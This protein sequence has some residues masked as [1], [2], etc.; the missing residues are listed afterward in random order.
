M[1]IRSF[2]SYAHFG[3][4]FGYPQFDMSAHGYKCQWPFGARVLMPAFGG[5]RTTLFCQ[6]AHFT[7]TLI[8]GA[9]LA[10]HNPA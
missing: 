6:L 3:G 4:A 2:H 9:F 1:P 5:E 8:P 7:H 10:I